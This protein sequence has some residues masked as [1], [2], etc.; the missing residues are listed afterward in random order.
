[1]L[2]RGQDDGGD[3]HHRRCGLAGLCA[4]CGHAGGQDHLRFLTTSAN[5]RLQSTRPPET[6]VFKLLCERWMDT[7]TAGLVAVIARVRCR[8]VVTT[9]TDFAGL[10]RCSTRVKPSEVFF[11]EQLGLKLSGWTIRRIHFTSD[12]PAVRHDTG[13]NTHNMNSPDQHQQIVKPR[14]TPTKTQAYHHR[15]H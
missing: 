4:S 9:I 14:T 15:I 8:A 10:G 5:L 11:M 12:P 1:M 7:G 13:D 2:R 3:G 6:G